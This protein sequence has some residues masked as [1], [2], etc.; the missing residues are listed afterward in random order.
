[1]KTGRMTFRGW[2]RWTSFWSPSPGMPDVAHTFLSFGFQGQDYVA[3]SIE[4]RR[5][6]GEDYS[7]VKNFLNVNEIIYIVGDERD[8]I[9]L[10]ANVRRDD[11]YLYHA[12]ITPQQS[13][14]LFV[15]MLQ[16]ANKLSTKPEFYNTIGNNCTTNLVAHVN[17]VVPNKIPYTYQVL[18]P[19]LSDR[20]AY[21]LGLLKSSGSFEETR[22]AARINRMAYIYRDSPDFSREIRR[23]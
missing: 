16:R 3:V 17:Q 2:T 8:L 15:D 12:N 20:L 13:Q 23:Y 18:L 14:A 19:G 11:V 7:P 6:R 22:A 10:R 9:R 5:L 1:M 4:V 21:N